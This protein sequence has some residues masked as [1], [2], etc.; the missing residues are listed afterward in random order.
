MTRI[1]RNLD[2]IYFRV[3]RGSEWQSVCYSDLTQTE[4]DEIASMR[5]KY[6]TPEE[7]TSW[8]RSIADHLADRLYD[9]GEQLGV[10]FY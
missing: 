8:W 7:Q 9:M 5:A 3:R 4:R 6:A 10:R 2:G 1:P